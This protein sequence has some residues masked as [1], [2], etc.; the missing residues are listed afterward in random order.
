MNGLRQVNV[1]RFEAQAAPTEANPHARKQVRVLAGSGYLHGFFTEG[2][3]GGEQFTVGVVEDFNGSLESHPVQLIEFVV[4][5]F[6]LAHGAAT[7]GLWLL[8]G[9]ED[10]N[11]IVEERDRLKAAMVRI[12]QPSEC[13]CK[14]CVGQ[15]L[16][17]ESMEVDLQAI[18]ELASE[19][20]SAPAAGQ[21]CAGCLGT[22]IVT[23]GC[24][25]PAGPH[26]IVCGTCRGTGRK[27]AA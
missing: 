10:P 17:Q 9:G 25:D 19:S 23:D 12:A 22:G 3:E 8:Q 15:C 4:P 27:E 18:R 14:P 6:K 13:G 11:A 2:Y 26:G 24:D 5:T 7:G 16:S 1:F 20:L 21:A